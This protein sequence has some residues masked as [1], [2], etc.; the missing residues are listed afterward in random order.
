MPPRKAT[1]KRARTGALSSRAQRVVFDES[2]FTSADNFTWYA[3]LKDNGMI[4]EKSI[5]P[6]ID[7]EVPIRAEFEN[8][9]WGSL[10]DIKGDYYPELVWQFYANM[11]DKDI[12]G[13]DAIRTFDKG[14]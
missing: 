10:L 1:S 3:K 14:G 6:R 12:T 2:R 5:H 7:A 4:F 8:F 13:M 11:E 9:G